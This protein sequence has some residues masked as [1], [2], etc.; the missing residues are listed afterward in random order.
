LFTRDL[1]TWMALLMNFFKVILLGQNMGNC[2]FRP[3]NKT[4]IYFQND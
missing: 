4:T 1:P 3:K 2:T